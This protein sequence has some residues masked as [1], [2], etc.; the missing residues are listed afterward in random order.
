MDSSA[1]IQIEQNTPSIREKT[2]PI[3][4][5]ER[6]KQIGAGILSYRQHPGTEPT[7]QSDA[8]TAR[9]WLPSVAHLHD[10]LRARAGTRS[11]N[12][13]DGPPT[14]AFAQAI[15]TSV[16][17]AVARVACMAACVRERRDVVFAITTC[18][19]V[20]QA[21]GFAFALQQVLSQ[22]FGRVVGAR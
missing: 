2:P 21:V 9:L 4:R 10:T 1:Y 11:R 12:R 14:H 7:P 5:R 6:E 18:P 15:H 8:F 20:L 17:M 16:S 13:P 22:V 3:N 19:H